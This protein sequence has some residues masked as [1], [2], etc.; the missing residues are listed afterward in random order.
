VIRE[1]GFRVQGLGFR[2]YPGG[3]L[4]TIFGQVIRGKGTKK[5]VIIVAVEDNG[6]NRFS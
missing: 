3:T 1:K 5:P 4:V 2:V 6:F